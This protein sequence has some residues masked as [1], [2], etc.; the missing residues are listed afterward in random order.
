MATFRKM[1]PKDPD[2]RIDYGWRWAKWLDGDTINSVIGIVTGTGLA[3]DDT[4]FD[5][6]NTK[7]WLTGGVD[8]TDYPVTTRITTVEGRTEDRT[9]IIPV[10]QK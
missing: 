4:E 1:K 8:G 9:F 6:T 5:A 7:L 3:V 10:R 2:S